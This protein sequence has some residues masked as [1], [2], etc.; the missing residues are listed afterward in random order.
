MPYT[1]ARRIESDWLDYR[2]LRG[3]HLK[4]NP[5][6]D[7]GWH[8]PTALTAEKIWKLVARR[9]RLRLADLRPDHTWLQRD[10]RAELTSQGKQALV[11]A[12]DAAIIAGESGR[13]LTTNT[14][15]D[16]LAARW[17]DHYRN[18]RENTPATCSWEMRDETLKASWHDFQLVGLRF[19]TLLHAA[20]RGCNGLYATKRIPKRG[21]T[22]IPTDKSSL[23]AKYRQIIN[24]DKE[25][26]RGSKHPRLLLA[27]E[28]DESIPSGVDRGVEDGLDDEWAHK[29]AA[30]WA[31]NVPKPGRRSTKVIQRL[32]AAR[33]YL[34]VPTFLK[35]VDELEKTV[36]Q[37]HDNIKAEY[38]KL[39]TK[40][41]RKS[42]RKSPLSPSR[43]KTIAILWQKYHAA[44]GPFMQL[45]DVRNQLQTIA[46]DGGP[47]DGGFVQ[48][49]SGFYKLSNRRYQAKNFWPTEV[50]GR[51][52]RSDLVA[53][54]QSGGQIT[55]DADGTQWRD[56]GH[57]ALSSV[58]S[59]RGRWFRVAE[60]GLEN[61]YADKYDW[62]DPDWA[63]DRRPL[64]GVDVSASQIQL[65]AVFLGLQDLE[66]DL[67]QQ[68]FKKR[69]AEL[70]WERHQ[71]KEDE[72][73]LPQGFEGPDDPKLQAAVKQAAMTHLYGSELKDVTHKLRVA[74]SQYGPGLGDA[75]NIE[76][77]LTDPQLNLNG[78]L[79]GFLP[80][81]R[82]IGEIAFRR[83]V[84]RARLVRIP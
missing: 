40:R 19:D 21:Y 78:I 42:S 54:A 10:E 39:R 7:A 35:D 33:L 74:P 36:K 67:A 38:A 77:L 50:T 25:Y 83:R 13:M 57:P 15:F 62:L 73:K 24:A 3:R 17:S 23:W 79:T 43:R 30:E 58:T 37:Q 70:A 51:D 69:S 56:A 26:R 82:R 8:R 80:A 29:V 20:Q 68:S 31:Y 84:P 27:D 65:L 45:K 49:R 75:K 72:F 76:R 41:K 5:N 44:H 4:S 12:L 1:G 11:V 55:V 16:A 18:A 28:S 6:Y 66:R 64:V 61:A 52:Y 9:L 81:C 53:V 60:T 32:E 71:N 46:A 59:R 48:I 2:K 22:V 14:I 34:H 63:G 47:D